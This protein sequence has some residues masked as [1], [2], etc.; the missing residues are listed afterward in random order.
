M[1]G[2]DTYVL[3]KRESLTTDIKSAVHTQDVKSAAAV[4]KMSLSLL[5]TAAKGS[6]GRPTR[7]RTR[8]TYY[9]RVSSAATVALSWNL[10]LDP[11]VTGEHAQFK[12]LFDEY[13]MHGALVR[14]AY[15]HNSATGTVLQK[16]AIRYT[17][18]NFNT[19]STVAEC[20]VADQSQVGVMT[21]AIGNCLSSAYG[22]SA[23]RG[24]SK[25]AIKIPKGTAV[26]ANPYVAG[27]QWVS[28]VE[29]SAPIHGYVSGFADAGLAITSILYIVT[30]DIE[31]RSRF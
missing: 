20:M 24:L 30:F 7:L 18:F 17:E 9:T 8:T 22:R 4:P 14:Y 23:D 16:Y 13:K 10:A 25:F 15:E 5:R 26:S 31:Y 1:I 21:G 3:V 6:A 29:T 2:E 28:T 27:Q 12:V 19:P 11:T